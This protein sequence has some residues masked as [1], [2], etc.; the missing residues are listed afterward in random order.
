MHS[1]RN[2]FLGLGERDEPQVITTR[3]RGNRAIS[4]TPRDPLL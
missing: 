4:A 3:C 2:V 1:R